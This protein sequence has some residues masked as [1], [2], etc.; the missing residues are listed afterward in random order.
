KLVRQRLVPRRRAAAGRG[1]ERSPQREAIVPADAGGLVRKSGPVQGGIEKVPAAVARE[2]PPGAVSPVGRRRQPHDEQP[3]ARIAETEQRPCPVS[4]APEPLD[5]ETRDLLP[6]RDQP[7]AGAAF[8]D[9]AM[10]RPQPAQDPRVPPRPPPRWLPRG[11]F[12]AGPR[13]PNPR[14]PWTS[15]PCGV[16]RN[17]PPP[18]NLPAPWPRS[19]ASLT[20][21]GLPPKS[22][23]FS[24]SMAAFA[25]SSLSRSAKA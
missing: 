20:L 19:S 24:S 21:S 5:L 2:H 7:R 4:P 10:Q 14:C 9:L 22:L 16:P 23:P 13:M 8:D 17:P 15:L 3:R 6:P 11:M 12:C 18:P 25:S 1:D